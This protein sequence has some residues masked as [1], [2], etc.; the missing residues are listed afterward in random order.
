MGVESEEASSGI[1]N[2]LRP[3]PLFSVVILTSL[4]DATPAY[5]G[6]HNISL[7]SRRVAA[8]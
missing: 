8:Q 6:G 4:V 1:L 5:R 3:V 7:A 2:T